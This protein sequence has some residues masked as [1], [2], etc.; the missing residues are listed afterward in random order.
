MTLTRWSPV[1]DLA[2]VEV[3]LLNRMFESAWGGESFA[4]AAW[5]PAVDIFE[6]PEKDVVVKVDLPDVKREDI[7]VTF[8]NNVLVIEGQREIVANV[9]QDRFYRFERAHGQFRRSFTLPATV[10][11]SR[12]DASYAEGVLTVKLPRR[13]ESKP[14]T[15]SV[16]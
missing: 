16:S 8:E 11:A 14:K 4:R 2:A 12:V 3:D 6:S 10:D 13:E 1:R 9:D 7:K 5:V 15:I